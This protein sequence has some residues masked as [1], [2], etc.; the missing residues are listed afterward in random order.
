MNRNKELSL[1]WELWKVKKNTNLTWKKYLSLFDNKESFSSNLN[2][3]IDIEF[4]LNKQINLFQMEI[5]NKEY[6]NF[7]YLAKETELKWNNDGISSILKE[8]FSQFESLKRIESAPFFFYKGDIKILERPTDEFISVV[9]SRKTTDNYIKWIRECVPKDKIIISGLAT[10]ADVL[11]HKYA[12]ENSQKIV[13]F[14]ALDIYKFEP[15]GAKWDIY[16]YGLSNGVILT[17]VIPSSKSYSDTNFLKRN[18]WMAQMVDETYIVYFD[19]ISGTLGQA[20]EVSKKG[21]KIIMS[22]EVF[23]KNESF[24]KGHNAFKTIISNIREI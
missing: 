21:G 19:G 18:K 6:L 13:I 10:G 9:G 8:D 11:G 16:K 22:K 1:F 3:L 2:S 24:L 20:L 5:F 7:I 12:I 23:R 4:N 14:P 15:L 17:D